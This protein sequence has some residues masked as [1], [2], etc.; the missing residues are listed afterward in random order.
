[1]DTILF[2]NRNSW[3]IVFESADYSI[4]MKK[5]YQY[6]IQ[7]GMKNNLCIISLK[8]ARLIEF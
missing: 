2:T 4:H 7:N 3:P 5:L 1:M 6:T 8:V